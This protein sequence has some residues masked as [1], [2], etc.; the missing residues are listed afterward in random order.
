MEGEKNVTPKQE[1]FERETDNQYIK[2][3]KIK[4]NLQIDELEELSRLL[5]QERKKNEE[6]KK[7][8]GINKGNELLNCIN[9]F[10]EIVNKI[11]AE[12]QFIAYKNYTKNSARF[13][14]V[15]KTIFEGYVDADPN[16]NKK[17]FY[18]LCIDFALLKSDENRKCIWNDN[19]VRIYFINKVLV[20]LLKEKQVES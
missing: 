1:N 10:C 16:I 14:K 13:C 18:D 15:E 4:C 6:L 11:I 19:P 5:E 20:D 3:L 7:G 12:D 17:L 2:N 8:K 9:S